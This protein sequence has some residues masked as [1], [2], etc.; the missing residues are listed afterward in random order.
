MMSRA[1]TGVFSSYK[2]YANHQM[3]TITRSSGNCACFTYVKVIIFIV[4][5]KTIADIHKKDGG[6]KLDSLKISLKFLV[7]HQ[8]PHTILNPTWLSS[9]DLIMTLSSD[10]KMNPASSFLL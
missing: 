2:C 8:T 4:Y 7:T 5:F 6:R 9:K 1:M 3:T 10:M